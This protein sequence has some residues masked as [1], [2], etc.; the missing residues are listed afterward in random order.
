MDDALRM[1]GQQLV[2]APTSP[3]C[4]AVEA[5]GRSPDAAFIDGDPTAGYAI[6]AAEIGP[7][8]AQKLATWDAS[9]K[10]ALWLRTSKGALHVRIDTAKTCFAQAAPGAP[11]VLTLVRMP[12]ERCEVDKNHVA[13]RS[14]LGVWEGVAS[15]SAVSIQLVR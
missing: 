1:V 14:S 11:D 10:Q 8:S 7:A 4:I 5:A 12:R 2:Y 9:G 13:C 15:N 3:G 6:E